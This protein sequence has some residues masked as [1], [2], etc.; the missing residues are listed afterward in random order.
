MAQHDRA[1]LANTIRKVIHDHL[2]NSGEDFSTAIAEVSFAL[3]LSLGHIIS[4]S[5]ANREGMAEAYKNTI[6]DAANAAQK[7]WDENKMD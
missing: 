2:K 6:L 3:C 5:Q 1:E 4:S 7:K